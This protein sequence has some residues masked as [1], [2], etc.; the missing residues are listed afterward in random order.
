M[1]NLKTNNRGSGIVTVII[2]VTFIAM[3]GAVLLFMAYMNLQIKNADRLTRDNFY[4]TET[5]LNELRAALQNSVSDAIT[6]SYTSTLIMYG[7]ALTDE[8]TDPQEKFAE[9]F[10]TSIAPPLGFTFTPLLPGDVSA[11]YK[12]LTYD[13]TKLEAT[14]TRFVSP[15]SGYN[16]STNQPSGGGIVIRLD[17]DGSPTAID[18][19]GISVTYVDTKGYENTIYS[20]FSISIPPFVAMSAGF[21]SRLNQYIIVADGTLYAGGATA[22]N[23]SVDLVGNVYAGNVD[24]DGN[25]RGYTLNLNSGRV[26]SSGKYIIRNGATLNIE[27]NAAIWAQ[28]IELDSAHAKLNGNIYIADD[29]E[30]RG[31]GSSAAITGSY[32]GFG[33]SETDGSN[34]SSIIISGP[35][36]ILD[37]TRLNTL[38]L[39][40][41]SFVNTNPNT[42]GTSPDIPMS[43]SLS[44]KSDQI[45]FLV[46]DGFIE[47]DGVSVPNPNI[48]SGGSV[49]NAYVRYP[50]NVYTPLGDAPASNNPPAGSIIITPSDALMSTYNAKIE[51]RLWPV[52][53]TGGTAV[54]YFLVFNDADDRA[55]Y[56]NNYYN[57]NETKVN[58]Y[59]SLYLDSNSA[60]RINAN[61]SVNTQGSIYQYVSSS[62]GYMLKGASYSSHIATISNTY[63]SQYAN[64]KSTLF[65]S[66]SGAG[67]PFASFVNVTAIQNEFSGE[68]A[69]IEF[70]D[71]YGNVRALILP[72]GYFA[73]NGGFTLD[74][75][76]Y[77]NV[78]IIIACGISSNVKVS[79]AFEGL[80]VSQG[81]VTLENS[82]INGGA[83]NTVLTHGNDGGTTYEAFNARST[84]ENGKLLLEYMSGASKGSTPSTIGG[85]AKTWNLNEL[86][87][88]RNWSKNEEN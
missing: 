72:E 52:S 60:G 68:T 12:R 47:R 77:P 13:N 39:A 40:G 20:D 16:I 58:E 82:L 1:A 81:D 80:I 63:S 67:T 4:Y 84:R 65:E 69:P 38:I 25:N 88:Y 5:A 79:R 66:E 24:V 64:L 42:G 26:I 51:Q 35:S 62:T 44:I 71:E 23:G 22:A 2:T 49:P 57:T 53:S 19:E 8:N 37:F 83:R 33:S 87:S 30:L 43:G 7:E 55:A 86:V 74:N 45:A 17:A 11:G 36:S 85:G 61:G 75:I 27:Q 15:A 41:R 48:W 59:L 70:K 34:S 9:N 32:F 56:F 46:P 14:L 29:L 6:S 78:N 73:V 31:S 50:S 10:I 18:I 21:Q 3:L 76:S 54:Y 28:R